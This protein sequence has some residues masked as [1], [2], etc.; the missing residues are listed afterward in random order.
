LIDR[1]IGIVAFISSIP[2][3]IPIHDVDQ[4]E[5]IHTDCQGKSIGDF[6]PLSSP[7]LGALSSSPEQTTRTDGN[8]SIPSSGEPLRLSMDNSVSSDYDHLQRYEPSRRWEKKR[9]KNKKK[10][11]E[12]FR[13]LS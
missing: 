11:E 10:E 13:L 7:V 12:T 9:K 3:S 5:R 2:K 4:G 6:S 1:S 8:L